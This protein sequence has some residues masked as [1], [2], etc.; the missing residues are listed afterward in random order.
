MIRYLLLL[1]LI[2]RCVFA[3]TFQYEQPAALKGKVLII[4]SLHPNPDFRGEKQPAIA[5]SQS[6]MVEDEDGSVET[7]LIQLIDRKRDSYDK[8]LK[9]NDRSIY[10][11]CETLFRPISGHH[12]TKVLCMVDDVYFK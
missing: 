4:K 6:V 12:T 8:L 1:L 3:Q 2:P 11:E 9:S 10:V 7:K 5:L